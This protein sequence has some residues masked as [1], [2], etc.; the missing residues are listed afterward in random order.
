MRL[1]A[2][3]TDVAV[4]PE[5]IRG[6][7]L[8]QLLRQPLGPQPQQH[9]RHV[10]ALRH[11]VLEQAGDLFPNLGAWC[12]PGHGSGL[13]SA[14][15]GELVSA[16]TIRVAQAVNFYRNSNTSPRLPLRVFE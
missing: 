14:P 1:G 16:H 11:A 8:E 4:P 12:Y 3:V 9:T 13:P 5:E 6:F 2:A 15:L 10:L 7:L